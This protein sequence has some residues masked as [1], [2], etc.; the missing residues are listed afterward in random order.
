IGDGCISRYKSGKNRKNLIL[1]TGS[2]KNDMFYYKRYI[3]KMIIKNFGISGRIYH[4]K[5][6]D[7]IRYFL[8]N[9]KFVKY[10][11][12]LGIPIGKKT[13]TVRVPGKILKS[14]KLLD[15]CIRGIFNTDGSVYSRYSKKY[16]N[17]KRH[18]RGY[19]IVQFKMKNYPLIKEIKQSL[20]SNNIKTTKIGIIEGKSIVRITNQKCVDDFF[21]IYKINHPHHLRRYKKIKCTTSPKVADS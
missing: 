5:D 16:S 9:Q 11:I 10:F 6:D 8:Y 20:E 21:R 13:E 2:W 14:K 18:Y 19:A 3:S 17:H 7:T 12:D 4:R 1:F 15:A